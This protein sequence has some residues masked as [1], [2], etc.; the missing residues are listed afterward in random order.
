MGENHFEKK[1]VALYALIAD[2]CGVA[3]YILLVI[4]KNCNPGN[5]KLLELLQ[6]Q[7]KKGMISCILYT[8]AIGASFIH[9]AIGGALIV[10]VAIMWLI[11][12]RNI[13]KSLKE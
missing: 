10:L 3:Y 5:E 13:E 1:T 4:I 2:L 9:E 11:P 8:V 12:D 6:K 7:S